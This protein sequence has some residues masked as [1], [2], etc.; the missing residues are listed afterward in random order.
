[1]YSGDWQ[2]SLAADRQP[3]LDDGSIEVIAANLDGAKYTLAVP[4]YLAD[5]G[6]QD[7]SDIAKFKDALGGK[8]YGIEPGN[9]GNRIIQT[10][11]DKD[12]FGLGVVQIGRIFRAGDVGT[13]RP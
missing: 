6:L 13:G 11:I 7:F 4:K 10:M 12:D 3:F 8:I 9:D 5:E 1:M 2:P